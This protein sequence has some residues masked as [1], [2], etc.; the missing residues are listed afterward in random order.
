MVEFVGGSFDG[1]RRPFPK[2][3]HDG[4]Q[5]TVRH[6][7][8]FDPNEEVDDTPFQG[9]RSEEIYVYDAATDRLRFLRRVN[10]Q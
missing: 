6:D 4:A 5:V 8:P 3:F 10:P 1:K 9:I 7:A 2:P